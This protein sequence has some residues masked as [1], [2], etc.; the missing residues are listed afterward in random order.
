MGVVVGVIFTW[1]FLHRVRIVASVPGAHT[2]K[3]MHKWGH[4]KLRK[5]GGNY[6]PAVSA[7]AK[8]LYSSTVDLPIS[9]YHRYYLST[10][11]LTPLWMNHGQWLVSFLA[12]VRW[13]RPVTAGSVL[14]GCSVSL[15]SRRQDHHPCTSTLTYNWLECDTIKW[16][17]Y[18][19]CKSI[20]TG[21]L[22]SLYNFYLCVL[23]FYAL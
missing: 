15:L 20:K 11:H 18:V 14:S 6:R 8:H 17:F 12:L 3:N 4:M 5:V 2:G 21:L 19:C 22:I 16:P 7:I 1:I 23:A 13:V 10:C 9:Y